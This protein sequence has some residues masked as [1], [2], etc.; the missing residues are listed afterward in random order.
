MN[1]DL[2]GFGG[3]G[4]GGGDQGS[5]GTE[6]P[7]S[8]HN[9]SYAKVLD[10]ISEG[11]IVGLVNGGQ[12]IYLNETPYLNGDGSAN[13]SGFQYEVRTGTQDQSYI[14]GFPDVE[15]EITISTELKSEAPW[16][17]GITN[18]QLSAVR[19]RL[20]VP[21]LS[22][23][24]TTNGNTNGYRI[25]YAIDLSTDGST[26]VQVLSAAFD[27]KT[28][29]KYERSHRVELPSSMTTGWQIRVR[30]LTANAHSVSIADTT[31]IESYT[32]I[33]DAK[34]RYPMSAMV[35]IVVDASQFQGI[36][37]RAYEVFGRIISVPSNYDPE[38]RI[39]NGL[40]DG[41]FKP[42]WTDCPPWIFYD[43][44]LND[45]YGVGHLINESQLDKWT[46][47]RIAQYCDELVPD[48]KGGTE[49]RFT[50][51]AYIQDAAA[52]YKVLQDLASVFRGILFWGGGQIVPAA[53]MPSD[54]VYV[55]TAAN[56]IDG[57]FQ[58]AGSSR[59]TRYT[60][61]LVSWNDPTDFYRAKVE[62]VS[63]DAAIERY[64][65][66]QTELTAFAC[67][68]QGQ[69]Q[70]AG[71]WT[72]KTSTLETG[73]K[74]WQVG[75]DGVVAAPGNVVL[76][77]D[78][79]KMGRRNAGRIRA[80]DGRT[81]VVDKAPVISVGD[82]FTVVLP[83]AV[84]ET[85]I[86]ESVDGD[87]VT[88]TQAYSDAP[89][90]QSLWTV[91][92]IDL[93]APVY[94]IASVT[95]KDKLT[96]EIVASRREPGK[97]DYIDSET[98]IATRP[99]SVVPMRYQPPPTN[100]RLST[101]SASTSVGMVT[102]LVIAWD[103][104]DGA[105]LYLP[106][107]RR[108]SGEW[109]TL[110][111]TGSLSV[112]VPGIYAGTYMARVRAYNAINVVS[113][114]VMVDATAL[115]GNT[116]P[117]PDVP[118]FFIDDDVLSWGAVVDAELAGYVIRYHYDQNTSWGDANPL[119]TGVLLASPYQAL[120]RP[121]GAITL[122][123]KAVNKS[124]QYSASP[125]VIL[126]A[127]GDALVANV[128]EDFDFQEMS[129][130]GS[131]SGGNVV[132][133]VIRSIG[134]SVFYRDDVVDFFVM[135]S[136]SAFYTDN[137]Q[138]MVYE[139]A[140]FSPSIVASGIKMTLDLDIE[141]SSKLIEY[142]SSGGEPFYQ[143]DNGATFYGNDDDPFFGAAA[144]Y[145]PW[146]GYVMAQPVQYQFRFS[147]G[148]GPVEGVID[149]CRVVIDVP[150]V[151]EKLNDIPIAATGTRLPLSK[152]YLAVKNVQLTLQADGGAAA[153][154][155]YLDKNNTIGPLVQCFNIAG[156]P[157]AGVIDASIQGY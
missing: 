114:V 100:L 73:V 129:Y 51:N 131:L 59:A 15:N 117:P 62:Y 101:Y 157:V 72:L 70:R 38:T 23:T 16:V 48:G 98:K 145:Q 82:P 120:N 134:T 137:Y 127:F 42:A 111:Q 24:D 136:E 28:T 20:S 133:G 123:I 50:C 90:V 39:Y 3:G 83:S 79:K 96:F 108:N 5:S 77:A 1:N 147:I 140:V 112:E 132:D 44:V 64:G 30:R 69:A 65:I 105:V 148:Q 99:T 4:K 13:F 41:T 58:D 33:I 135:D 103:A 95:E 92:N 125:A 66:Q 61:A 71:R 81:I 12:S 128:V 54:P 63:D 124:G 45:R 110:P 10:L 116:G 89:Q 97:F 67:S 138:S 21:A 29:S 141:G 60:V 32:E 151:D 113:A 7:D 94:R 146:P 156:V 34:L 154:V 152:T 144:V 8:L 74:T 86:V 49:P 27:G 121:A 26:F 46:L 40:W 104:P 6:T 52:A 126:S 122:M 9:S 153:S 102:T 85:R 106:E 118:W 109:V 107:W 91:D 130:P 115:D 57:K 78:P 80:V 19:I 55:Y 155:K 11:P 143:A 35:G 88:V 142:R 37:T 68:S 2:R 119:H 18:R 93:V 53:D 31:T 75:L 76:V 36:P 47:Y 56:V 14:P 150:D 25:E 43:M 87:A 149:A 139:T 84:S 17:R 22:Q